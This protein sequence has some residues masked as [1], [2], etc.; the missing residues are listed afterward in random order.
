MTLCLY[1]SNDLYSCRLERAAASTVRP[2]SNDCS[3][4][5]STP[6]SIVASFFHSPLPSISVFIRSGGGARSTRVALPPDGE[7]GGAR[8]IPAGLLR[9]HADLLLARCW[10]VVERRTA[11]RWN[12]QEVVALRLVS[13]PMLC[14]RAWVMIVRCISPSVVL[15]HQYYYHPALCALIEVF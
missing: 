3:T 11:A 6:D 1:Y 5:Q 15:D 7:S 8:D 13:S 4:K 14:G 12:L 2:A 9:T 10:R